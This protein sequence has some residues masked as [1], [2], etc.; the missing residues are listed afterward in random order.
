MTPKVPCAVFDCVVLLQAAVSQKGPAFACLRHARTDQLRIVLSAEVLAE[1]TDVL[2]RPELQ[3]KFKTLTPHVADAFLRD[4]VENSDMVF[5]VPEVFTYHR[6]PD[7]EPQI[8]LAIAAGA[9]YLVTWDNDMLDLMDE[10]TATGSDFRRR[11]PH[12]LILSPVALIRE[13]SSAGPGADQT[14]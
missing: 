2:N 11:F 6:A 7:D 14:E 5:E 3:R 12:L 8:N 13:I 1:I 10:T 9:R 4:L